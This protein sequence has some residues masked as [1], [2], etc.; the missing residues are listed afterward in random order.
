M[1]FDCHNIKES[2]KTIAPAFSCITAALSVILASVNMEE[3]R[4]RYVEDQQTT[5]FNNWYN[6]LV[7]ERHLPSLK[8]FFDNC[9]DLILVLYGIN[10]NRATL[11]GSEYDKEIQKNVVSKFT[12]EYTKI[13]KDIVFDICIFDRKL[14]KMVSEQFQQFQ[15][16]FFTQLEEININPDKMYNLVKSKYNTIVKILMAFNVKI[17]EDGV[18]FEENDSI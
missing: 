16:Q 17:L 11:T 2:L 1:S 10:Q 5:V 4:K 8:T 18:T 3:T 12:T 14:S 7:T 6:D 13:H 15:D 9:D